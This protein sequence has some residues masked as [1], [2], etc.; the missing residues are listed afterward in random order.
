MIKADIVDRVAEAS[1]VT[2][3]KAAEGV[4]AVIDAIKSALAATSSGASGC[5][6]SAT[7]SGAWAA[8]RRPASK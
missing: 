5:S 7:A 8:T 4:D 2:R 6:R 3:I 1:D